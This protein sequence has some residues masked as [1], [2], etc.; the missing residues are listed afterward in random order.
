MEPEK[1]KS[2]WSVIEPLV[3]TIPKASGDHRV[4]ILGKKDHQVYSPSLQL[5]PPGIRSMERNWTSRY[6]Y[7]IGGRG[8]HP[9]QNPS[10]W[11]EGERI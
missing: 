3:V 7:E 2:K 9:R 6:T 10:S 11:E 8:F 4:D 1:T 5:P